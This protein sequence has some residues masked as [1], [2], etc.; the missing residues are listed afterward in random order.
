MV[1]YR[2]RAIDNDGK[3][4]RGSVDAPSLDAARKAVEDTHVEVIE[5]AEAS[6]VAPEPAPMDLAPPVKAS[7]AF[8]GKDSSGT[9]RR[10]SMQAE[11]K[12]E[13]FQK[14]QAGQKLFLTMLSPVGVTPQF[15]DHDL[16]NWQKGST[17]PVAAV[18]DSP[19]PGVKKGEKKPIGFA[20]AAPAV[21]PTTVK[22]AATH[23]TTDGHAYAPL[24]STLRLYAGWLLAWYGLFVSL[25]YY[26]HSRALP[27][28]VPY[29]EA[30]FLSPLIFSFT[31]AIFL[32]LVLSSVH[33]TVHGK[34]LSGILFGI[35]GIVL[36][37]GVRVAIA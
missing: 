32:F 20:M 4:I 22:A 35:F 27:W 11:N 19:P 1:S 26:V 31:V 17:A 9:V 14:L 24:T 37:F 8:E 21:P 3:E 34:F 25:G 16:E 2:Y 28:S 13:A 10:G 15:R 30:F 6:R 12:F 36:F 5:V 29:V 33:R 18:P 23:Q 7:F